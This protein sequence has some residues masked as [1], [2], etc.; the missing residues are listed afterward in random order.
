[1]MKEKAE[2]FDRDDR[3]SPGVSGFWTASIKRAWLGNDPEF[4]VQREW[5]EL[6]HVLIKLH[7]D[8]L[9]FR[10]HSGHDVA[11][12]HGIGKRLQFCHPLIQTGHRRTFPTD[13]RA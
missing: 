6:A 12:D 3:A 8:H 10:F 11:Q 1:M 9:T 2:Q 4:V 13:T 7:P 5:V